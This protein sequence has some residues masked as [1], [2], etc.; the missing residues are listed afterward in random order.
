MFVK[1]KERMIAIY[2][3]CEEESQDR[4]YDYGD[5]AVDRDNS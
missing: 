3:L 2:F 1:M 4:H 5:T